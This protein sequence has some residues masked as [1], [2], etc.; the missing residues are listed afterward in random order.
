MENHFYYTL[1]LPPSQT[2]AGLA[3]NTRF[4]KLVAWYDNECGYSNRVIDLI[5][6]MSKEDAEAEAE[7]AA[8]AA[9]KEEMDTA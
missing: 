4:V 3:L 6:H 8:A 2:G 1:S 7:E 5:L 9:A